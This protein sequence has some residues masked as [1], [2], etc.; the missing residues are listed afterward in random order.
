VLDLQTSKR[1]FSVN[2]AILHNCIYQEQIME[3][4]H[5]VAGLDYSAADTFRKIMD[6]LKMKGKVEKVALYKD[7]FIKGCQNHSKLKEGESNSLWKTIEGFTGYTFPKSH[8][9][10]YGLL[11]YWMSYIRC[12]YFKAFLLS[13]LNSTEDRKKDDENRL[14]KF[15]LM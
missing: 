3:L 6:D 14:K 2:G 5:K 7:A 8:S 1:N 10:S 15:L 12:H 4:L 11:T 13:S 9:C